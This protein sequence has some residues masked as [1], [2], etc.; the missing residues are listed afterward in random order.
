L[1]INNNSNNY[2]TKAINITNNFISPIKGDHIVS[3]ET[4]FEETNIIDINYSFEV[5]E[6]PDEIFYITH[7]N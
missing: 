1:F 7:L 3:S 6:A 4:I 5:I 2:Q